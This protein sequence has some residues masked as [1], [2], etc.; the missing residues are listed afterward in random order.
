M[1]K[2]NNLGVRQVTFRRFGKKGWCIFRSLSLCVRIGVLAV[3]TQATAVSAKNHADIVTD[4]QR[5]SVGTEKELTE[6]AITGTVAPLSQLQSARIVTVITRDDITQAGVQ[7]VNDLFKL[8]SGV[9]VRQR[10]GFG[11]QTDIS[12]NGG[13]NEQVAILLNGV[14]IS[15]PQTGH[16]AA[17]FPVSISD[18]ERIEVL[19][20]SASRVYGGQAFGGAINVVTKTP[21]GGH[22]EAGVEGGM[23]G[24]VQG[25]ARVAWQHKRLGMS[26]SGGG[27]RSDGGTIND[28]WQKGQLYFQGQYAFGGSN[29]SSSSNGSSRLNWQFGYSRKS[30]GAN[31]FYSGLSQDQWEQNERFLISVGGDFAVLGLHLSPL[32]YWNR[33][34]DN[35]HWHKGTPNNSHQADVYGAKISGWFNWTCGRTAFTADMRNEGILSSSLGVLMDEKDW[36]WGHGADKQYTRKYNRTNVS[37]N[38]EHNILLRHWTVSMGVIANMNTGVDSRWRFYPGVDV[39]YYPNATWKFYASY[40]MGF[41]L[42]SFTDLFYS[43]PDITGNNQLKPERNHN[44]HIGLTYTHNWISGN[45]QVFYNRGEDMIDYVKENWQD[46][47][48]SDNFDRD[49]VGTTAEVRLDFRKV[50]KGFKG[51]QGSSK[52]SLTSYLPVVKIGYTYLWSQ[53]YGRYKIFTSLY[54]DDYLRHKLVVDIN[55]K[56]FSRLSATWSVRYQNRMGAYQVYESSNATDRLQSYTPYATLDLKLQWTASKYEIYVK[57]TNITNCRYQDLGNIPQPGAW[58]LAGAR[59]KY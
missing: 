4:A 39:A 12:I 29:G 44:V 20:G 8:A 30:Y 27:G 58:I 5:D 36:V 53:R 43:S 35:Y 56:I 3:A 34:Y 33:T 7:S 10:G 32:V 11:V 2:G 9:D 24:T 47:A 22:L 28:D 57:G 19:E 45:A 18:I 48:H 37:F 14:N 13:T 31:T 16:L 46:V 55:H 26:L 50:S 51:F 59:I 15:N 54:G 25:D 23:Y 40:N 38:L 52:S 17:D 1:Y 6:V 21:Q 49:Q 42:P 41:R